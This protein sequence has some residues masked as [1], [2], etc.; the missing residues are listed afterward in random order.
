[1]HNR[2]GSEWARWDV[3][4]HTPGTALADE[5][6]PNSLDDWIKAVNAAEPPAS[7]LGVTDYLS[8]RRY[9]EIRARW[10]AGDLPRVKFIFPN[11]EFRVSPPTKSHKG[12]NFHLLVDPSDTDHIERMEAALSSLHYEY[13]GQRFNCDASGLERLGKTFNPHQQG[14]DAAYREGVNAFKIDFTQ[15]T[16]WFRGDA[17]LMENCLIA[18]GNKEGDGISGL[19]KEHGYAATLESM[20]RFAQIIL[21]G[22]PTDR[23]YWL[24]QGSDDEKELIRRF[25]GT[26]PCL[27]GCDAHSLSRVL[28]PEQD[29]LCWIRAELTFEGLRQVVYEPCERVHIGPERPSRARN[30][31]IRSVAVDSDPDWFPAEPIELN[32]GLV[33]VIGPRGSGKTA[34]ADLIAY[35][36]DAFDDGPG[37]FLS[38]ALPWAMGSRIQLEW[39]HSPKAAARFVGAPPDEF[40]LPEVRY[41]SQHFVEQLC[42]S[43]GA[44]H[45]LLQEIEQVVYEALDE[46]DRSGTST[47]AEL[48]EILTQPSVHRL[49]ELQE[50][51]VSCSQEIS[52]QTALKMDLPRRRDR[53]QQS[54]VEIAELA[55]SLAAIAVKGKADKVEALQK[56]RNEVSKLEG[57]VALLKTKKKR[58]EELQLDL[59]QRERLNAQQFEALRRELID[60]GVTESDLGCFQ[61]AA[62]GD[63]RQVL[64]GRIDELVGEIASLVDGAKVPIGFPAT[65]AVLRERAASLVKTIGVDELKER[66]IA[67]LQRRQAAKLQ[68]HA[69]LELDIKN[70]ES[71]D[72]V[73]KDVQSRRLERYVEVFEELQ[74]QRR[75]LERLY[76]PLEAVLETAPPER[77]NLEFFVRTLVDIKLWAERG[78]SLLDRRRKGHVFEQD[79]SLAREAEKVLGAAWQ[80][81]SR[82]EIRAGMERFL[83]NFR[84]P[85]EMLIP[86]ATLADLAKWL[87][88]TDHVRIAYSIRYEGTEIERLSPG[89]RGIVLLILYLALD[90]QDDRPLVIDQPEENLDPQ[91]IYSVLTGYFRE[92]RPRRQVIIV[93]HNPNLVVNTDVDQVII[94]SSTR[95]SEETL[96]HLRYESGGLEVP[97]VRKRV[98]EVLEGGERAFLDRARRYRLA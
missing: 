92:I 49:Q 19:A 4:I 17:W 95:V 48:R 1:M 12:V 44:S 9:K 65:L 38:K 32:E 25:G 98:C 83:A 53:H 5:Y 51:I 69:K 74:R 70:S 72:D 50:E 90:T 66:Q 13:N 54:T 89:T 46:T 8:I 87:F 36:A 29:R 33:A 22:N 15:F 64:R 14:D 40:W 16:T 52:R 23:K 27:H 7:A 26:K 30:N 75:E 21:S 68:E 43:D 20:G 67:D 39:A 56:V 31:W 6:P 97:E 34:L 96:P 2:R 84:N 76:R 37:S 78:E 41:L 86:T 11:I 35:G 61:M 3:H 81:G 94:A 71:S 42:S 45:R 82:D 58:L 60:L 57:A 55:K 62:H 93:T 63:F 24:G 28:A 91:S 88:S 18:V 85:G 10:I 79:G 59:E 73:I 47:F 80:S 77:K